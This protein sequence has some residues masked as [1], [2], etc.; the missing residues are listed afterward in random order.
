MSTQSATLISLLIMAVLAWAFCCLAHGYSNL[1]DTI[2]LL[3]HRHAI[4]CKRRQE[5]R[6]ARVQ[7]M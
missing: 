2:A 1:V 6:T 3:L 5:R 4:E 7:E